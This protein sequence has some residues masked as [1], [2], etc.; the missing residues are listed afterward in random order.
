MP[1]PVPQDGETV[2][3]FD[4]FLGW[5]RNIKAIG[6]LARFDKS[7]MLVHRLESAGRP[8]PLA[9]ALRWMTRG[10]VRIEDGRGR[11]RTIDGGTLARW[12]VQLSVEPFRKAALLREVGRAV[13]SLEREAALRRPM[14]LDLSKP[15]LYLRSDLSFGVRA[16]GSV[17]HIAGVVNH[18]GDFA[19]PPILLSTDDVPTVNAAIETHVIEP[20]LDFWNFQELPMFVQNDACERAAERAIAGRPLAF[21]Y[22]R[23]STNNYAGIRI[24]RRYG[25]P[26]VLEY[27]G[28]EVWVARHWGRPLKYETLTDRVERLNLRSADLV[29]VVSEPLADQLA[30][31]GVDRARILMNPNGVDPDRYSPGIDG[32]AVRARCGWRDEIV[33][34]FIGTFGPWHGADVLARAFADL[35]DADPQL[36]TPVRLLMIGDGAGLPAVRRIIDA[37]RA[38]EATVFTGLIPQEDGP[39]HL[40]ACDILIA[41][42]VPNADGTPFFGSPTKLFEYMAMGKAIVASNLDQLGQVLD[43]GRS[44]WLVP[45]GDAGALA[46]GI[47]R[48]IVAPELRAALGAAARRCAVDRYTWREHTRRTIEKLKDLVPG[49]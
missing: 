32:R 22:Q 30:T 19:A 2:A 11:T 21:V 9:L 25:V 49:V 6:M 33:V 38:A 4:D 41:P 39:Q 35:R 45:P 28:S 42:H 1:L 44:G 37:R 24:A 43:H 12:I 16:G 15:P 8:L 20:S 31:A 47:R 26:L 13:D 17:G 48:L 40:A 29:V 5:I 7:R 46:E 3:G 18:L 10:D 27:N 14:T 34:G 23:Y 36:M